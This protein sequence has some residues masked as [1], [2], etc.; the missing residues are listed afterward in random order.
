M[1]RPATVA[2]LNDQLRA[3]VGL[4]VFLGANEPKLGTI[5]MTCGIMAL[6]PEQI[7]DVWMKVR[8]FNSFTEG[9]DPYGEHDFGS[10]TLDT[11]EKI[12]WKI[13]YFDNAL[14]MHSADAANPAITHRVLTIMLASEY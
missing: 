5:L 14:K 3:R 10:V 12:F 9:N 2:K 13:D 4:P 7:I 1:S 8:S 11:G 6:E